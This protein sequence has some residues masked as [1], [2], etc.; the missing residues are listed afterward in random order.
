MT[1]SDPNSNLDLTERKIAAV[2]RRLIREASL[3]VSMLEDALAA[4]WDLN[5]PA[6]LAV[7]QSDDRIDEEEVAIEQQTHEVLALHHPF[8]RNFRALVFILKVNV[9]LERVADHAASIAK[10]VPK[11][12]AA[13]PPGVT[14]QWP[15]ALRELGQRV[16]A[17]C[18][19]LMRAV[20]DEDVE[21]ARSLVR[22][23]DVIDELEK[24]L[25]DEIQELVRSL[26]RSDSALTIGFL[27]YRIGR[28][29]ERVGDLMASVAED[30]VYVATGEI[31]RHEKRRTPR[32]TS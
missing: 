24:R 8:G 29:L 1:P 12:S 22:G 11:I 14:L 7:R 6:A 20:L 17:M 28:E 16:P 4:L 23:D 2:K 19:G 10:Q 18:H 26:N 25:F 21:G 9:E 32:A 31:I 5:I 15:T 30:V 13:L 3:A 27:V